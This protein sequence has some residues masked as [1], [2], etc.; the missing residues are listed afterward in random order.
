[1]PANPEASEALDELA[2]QRPVGVRES[3]AVELRPEDQIATTATNTLQELD[4]CRNV[5]RRV[6]RL[7]ANP[8]ANDATG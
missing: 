8:V 6:E 4:D 2:E 7:R 5:L 3:V 1:M